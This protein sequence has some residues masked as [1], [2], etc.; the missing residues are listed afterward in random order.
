MATSFVAMSARGAVTRGGQGWPPRNSTCLSKT[1]EFS[2]NLARSCEILRVLARSLRFL[3][4]LADSRR[5]SKPYHLYIPAFT[6]YRPRIHAF[7]AIL[8]RL[9]HWYSRPLLYRC[10]ITF[11][12]SIRRAWQALT[13]VGIYC[14]CHARPAGSFAITR[15]APARQPVNFFKN[16]RV[17]AASFPHEK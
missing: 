5:L 7:F 3:R 9:P 4:V 17:G 12:A 11:A 8:A 6:D 2:P 16:P 14:K 1:C 13:A 15:Q 10:Q